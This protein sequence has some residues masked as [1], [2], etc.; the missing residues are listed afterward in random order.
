VTA[1]GGYEITLEPVPGGGVVALRSSEGVIWAADHTI[2]V[3]DRTLLPGTTG[4][5]PG[6]LELAGLDAPVGAR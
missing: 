6:D 3:V 1:D 2:T 4:T 5:G